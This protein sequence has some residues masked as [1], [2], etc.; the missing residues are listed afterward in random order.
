MPSS[1]NLK[2]RNSVYYARLK[3]PVELQRLMG[4]KELFRSLNKRPASARYDW[5]DELAK[6]PSLPGVTD[7]LPPAY[8]GDMVRA[9]RERQ[10]GR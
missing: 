4:T 3:V 1:S 7:R 8:D 10:R 6:R 5:F 2:I 9:A